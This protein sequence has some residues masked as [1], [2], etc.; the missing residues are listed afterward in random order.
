[1]EP[2]IVELLMTALGIVFVTWVGVLSW[3]G[4]REVSRVDSLEKT[5][6]DKPDRAELT[7]AINA[8]MEKIDADQ[9]KASESRALIYKRIQ[10]DVHERHKLDKTLQRLIGA[11][12][13]SGAL[14]SA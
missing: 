2:T 11:L 13:A 1:M 6:G 3:V 5:V 7:A 8:I 4:K 9:K 14:K 10:E 12:E